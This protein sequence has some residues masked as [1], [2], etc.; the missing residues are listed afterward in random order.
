MFALATGFCH[1]TGVVRH[2]M[3]QW[4]NSMSHQLRMNAHVSHQNGGVGM[5]GGDAMQ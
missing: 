1:H 4:Y 3:Q 5:N 2:D